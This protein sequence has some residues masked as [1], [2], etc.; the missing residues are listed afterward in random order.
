MDNNINSTPMPEQ[1]QQPVPQTPANPSVSQPIQ[2]NQVDTK[3][4][5]MMLWV[6]VVAIFGILALGGSYWYLS[7]IRGSQTSQVATIGQ[8][9]QSVSQT[10]AQQSLNDLD[11]QTKSI[12]IE[13][14]DT[15]FTTVDKDLNSL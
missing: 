12:Q 4:S 15:T 3:S 5:N 13:N 2:P 8:K 11:N 14:E 10:P 7:M 9:T 6:L 1:S